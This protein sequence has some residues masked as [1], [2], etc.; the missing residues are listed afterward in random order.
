MM[1]EE[2]IELLG[3]QISEKDYRIIENVYTWHPIFDNAWYA[4][5]NP[6]SLAVF[7]YKIGG[8]QIF[9]DLKP[10]ADEME[11]LVN[12]RDR[13][14]IKGHENDAKRVGNR[15]DDIVLSYEGLIEGGED[16]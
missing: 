16:E 13:Y 15:I 11:N 6:K 1:R 7:F 2:F 4:N 3:A 9:L 10:V 14:R 5:M 8:L 12:K